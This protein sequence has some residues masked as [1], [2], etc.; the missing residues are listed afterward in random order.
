MGLK[1][2]HDGSVRGD[3]L[4]RC[5]MCRAPTPWW[6]SVEDVALC[7]TCAKKT[8]ASELPRKAEWIAKERAISGP[9]RT[10]GWQ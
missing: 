1:I 4:E 2:V 3:V 7:P 9:D 8:K 10:F 5:C 6:R